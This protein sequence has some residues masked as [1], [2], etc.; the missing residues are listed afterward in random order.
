MPN[1]TA[2]VTVT[3][4]AAA[5]LTVII[6]GNE[7]L[8]GG[9]G[10][11]TIDLDVG[12]NEIVIVVGD[13][14]QTVT[15]TATFFHDFG[16]FHDRPERGGFTVQHLSEWRPRPADLVMQFAVAAQPAIACEDPVERLD[17]LGEVFVDLVSEGDSAVLSTVHRI[18]MN[19]AAQYEASLAA[20]L[21]RYDR[22]HGPRMWT[23]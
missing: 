11:G 16:V 20:L 23:I 15:Y 9:D 5:N 17:T 2:S 13:G 10:S 1:G 22:R 14:T 6:N 18:W 12:E 19:V 21:D 7:V 4:D 3:V 8:P